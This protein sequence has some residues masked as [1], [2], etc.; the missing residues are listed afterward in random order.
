MYHSFPFSPTKPLIYIVQV[1]IFIFVMALTHVFLSILMI[2]VA[3]WRINLW[4]RWKEDDSDEYSK[5][6]VDILLVCVLLVFFSGCF[7][8]V[9]LGSRSGQLDCG[10]WVVVLVC[11]E[12][13]QVLMIILW[14]F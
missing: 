14:T 12:T 8:A 6:Y 5:A 9:R 11:I 10:G 2:L 3:S 1:H 4:K 13:M 7:V